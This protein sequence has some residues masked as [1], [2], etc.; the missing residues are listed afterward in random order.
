MNGAVSIFYRSVSP[1][2]TT[3]HASL[4]I[5]TGIND[6]IRNKMDSN[7]IDS[8]LFTVKFVGVRGDTTAKKLGSDNIYQPWQFFLENQFP[9]VWI[10]GVSVAV[11]A[12]IAIYSSVKTDFV[13]T[14]L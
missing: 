1:L 6:I 8:D 7:E 9:I 5:A 14:R 2:N 10:V 3:L 13:D 12:A 4:D 11:I